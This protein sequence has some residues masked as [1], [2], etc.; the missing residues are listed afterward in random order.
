MT[1]TSDCNKLVLQEHIDRINRQPAVDAEPVRHG[2]WMWDILFEDENR[3][4]DFDV[5]CSACGALFSAC[6]RQEAK[7]VMEWNYCICGAK[8]DLED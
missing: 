1:Q 4:D 3:R 5:K 7:N 6:D 8:M 2:R